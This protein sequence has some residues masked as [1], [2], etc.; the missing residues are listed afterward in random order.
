VNRTYE[1][2]D[3]IIEI[4]IYLYIIFIFLTKGEGIRNILLFSGFFLWLVTI[5]HRENRTILKQP[6]S[7]LFWVFLATVFTSA[8]FSI[9]PLYSY[10]SLRGDP[11]KSFM[12]FC[13]ISTTFP[14][15]KRLKRFIYLS[16]FILIFT[17]SVGYYSYFAYDLP[18]MK[19][20]TAIRHAWHARFTMDI[21]TLL[22][23]TLIIFMLSK[24][25]WSRTI[26]SITFLI[27]MSA[28]IMSTSRGGIAAF[29]C[30]SL[31][32][33]IYLVSKK[34]INLKVL[35]A[36]VIAILLLLGT[37]VAYSPN[38]K[39]RY[40]G[41][42]RDINT[43]HERVD[44]WKPLIAT[45]L[46]RPV[47][48]WGYG[49]DIFIMDEPFANTTYKKAPVHIKGA[50]RNPHNSFLKIFFHQG[51]IGLISYIALFICTVLSLWKNAYSSNGLKSY[52]LMA[53]TSIMIG[54]FF[55]NSIVENPH[56]MDL[57][58]ILGI[59]LAAKNI[60]NEDSH[61]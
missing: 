1:I 42:A 13:L 28:V 4:E 20:V 48:G 14:D 30:I 58:L 32:W 61:N 43:L 10:K 15:Q 56:I 8:I 23:F 25:I 47:T 12:F 18:L 17:V 34:R 49:P 51:I 59:G 11:L 29:I 9:D 22:P 16:Y 36:G 41:I 6:V 33:L 37:I 27:S 19:P 60:K 57:T 50:F 54:T 26:L 5:S 52:I 46:E 40:E 3:R 45:A 38:V 39:Q 55:I 31:V 21:N 44:I 2:I 24:N 35:L 7:I 53:C